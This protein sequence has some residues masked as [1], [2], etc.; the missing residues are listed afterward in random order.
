AQAIVG[1]LGKGSIQ[2]DSNAAD[3]HEAKLLRLDVTKARTQL[4]WRP[5]WDFDK[6]IAQTADWY[7]AWANGADVADLCKTQIA[8][9]EADLATKAEW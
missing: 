9:F 1:A 5:V 7:G 4:G 3:L 8:E 2:I 6:T